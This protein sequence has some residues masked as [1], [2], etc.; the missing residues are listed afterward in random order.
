MMMKQLLAAVAILAALPEA[1]YATRMP[2]ERPDLS[3]KP[4]TVTRP[5]DLP[6]PSTGPFKPER[7]QSFQLA[8]IEAC[9]ETFNDAVREMKPV[10]SLSDAIDNAQTAGDAV[11]ECISSCMDEIDGEDN[12]DD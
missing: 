8:C 1:A 7:P 9:G 10:E 11:K 12:D 3:D 5:L 2:P 6:K 4:R